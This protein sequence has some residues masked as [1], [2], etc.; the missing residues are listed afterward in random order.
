V[1]RALAEEKE[2]GRLREALDPCA[3]GPLAGRDG[4]PRARAVAAVSLTSPT[5]M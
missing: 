1:R 5:H 3:H 4:P 2:Q